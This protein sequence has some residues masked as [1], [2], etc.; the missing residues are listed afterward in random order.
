M[1]QRGQDKGKVKKQNDHGQGGDKGQPGLDPFS[2]SQIQLSPGMSSLSLSLPSAIEKEEEKGPRARGECMH[3]VRT[4]SSSTRTIDESKRS[5]SLL[6]HGYP[7]LA[8]YRVGGGEEGG[9]STKR[10]ESRVCVGQT[11][12]PDRGA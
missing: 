10:G 6:K 7:G 8:R 12:C 2:P 5:M 3:L 4:L 11:H 9:Q 1:C